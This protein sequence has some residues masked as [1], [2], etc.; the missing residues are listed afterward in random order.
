MCVC[1]C[2]CVNVWVCDLALKPVATHQHA[3][4]SQEEKTGGWAELGVGDAT[5]RQE[6]RNKKKTNDETNAQICSL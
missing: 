6:S 4:Q 5:R 2:V 3:G 1:V